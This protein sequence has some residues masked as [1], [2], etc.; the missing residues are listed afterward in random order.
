MLLTEERAFSVRGGRTL[1][2]R[3]WRTSGAPGGRVAVALHGWL[4]NAASFDL[5]AP[6]LVGLGRPGGLAQLVALD[7]A[8]HGRSGHRPEGTYSPADHVGDVCEVLRQ[9]GWWGDGDDD[10]IN[11]TDN[12]AASPRVFLVGHSMGGGIAALLAGSFPEHFAGLILLEALGPW[13]GLE[14]EAPKDLRN[15][16]LYNMRRF[17]GVARPPRIYPS[18][19]AAAER[20]AAGNRVGKLPV[21]AALVLC[22]R[23]LKPLEVPAVPAG[24]DADVPAPPAGF[25]WSADSALMG[26]TRVRM[27][28]G[29]A[30]AFLLGLRAPTLLVSVKDGI[31]TRA[32][33]VLGGG[34]LSPWGSPMGLIMRVVL[35][36]VRVLLAARRA[37][38]RVLGPAD[39]DDDDDDHGPK[40][41]LSLAEYGLRYGLGLRARRAAIASAVTLTHVHLQRGGHHPQLT[42]PAAVAHACLQY[43]STV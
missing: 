41:K 9:L 36:V 34:V 24:A 39:D 23:G 19:R 43:L 18:A 11:N 10:A 33:H 32:T 28:P 22:S 30:R 40:D 12:T 35:V 20:R 16:T 15:G 8:G 25:V 14:D 6:L 21:A 17:A 27:S 1:A 4:D 26:P 31:M 7:L 42:V 37:W 3:H 38:R 29:Q 2:A 13:P 5:L